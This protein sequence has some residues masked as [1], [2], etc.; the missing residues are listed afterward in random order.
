MFIKKNNILKKMEKIFEPGTYESFLLHDFLFLTN[1][2]LTV[3][4][5]IE[6]ILIFGFDTELHFFHTVDLFF[7]ILFL[8]EALLRLYY[9]YLP[10]KIFF[11]PHQIVNWIVIISLM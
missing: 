6:L 8:I 11:K 2:G 7:G 4:M 5:I 3:L 1:I 10:N 9:D